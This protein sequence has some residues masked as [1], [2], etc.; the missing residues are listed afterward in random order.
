MWTTTN[1]VG[2]LLAISVI[3]HGSRQRDG[4]LLY[5]ATDSTQPTVTFVVQSTSNIVVNFAITFAIR[6]ILTESILHSSALSKAWLPE[7]STGNQSIAKFGLSNGCAKFCGCDRR[8]I[9]SVREQRICRICR[10]FCGRLVTVYPVAV[11]K[12]VTR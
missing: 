4:A 9:G 6:E 5:L 10:I 11:V 3:Q 8:P 7:R 2:R 12:V 1:D